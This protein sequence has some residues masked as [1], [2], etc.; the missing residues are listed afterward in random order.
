[1]EDNIICPGLIMYHLRCDNEH[2][3]FK[4]NNFVQKLVQ[5][6]NVKKY[7]L[8]NEIG[9]E[10]KKPH[11]QGA[12]WFSK[13]QLKKDLAK[14]RAFLNSHRIV[15]KNHYAFTEAKNP[16]SLSKYAKKEGDYIHNLSDQEF[17]RIGD[18]KVKEKDEKYNNLKKQL[19]QIIVKYHVN[20]MP[21]FLYHFKEIYMKIYGKMCTN[22][23]TYI[24]LAHE[25]GVISDYNLYQAIGLINNF[26]GTCCGMFISSGV[27]EKYAQ[28]HEPALAAAAAAAAA[29]VPPPIPIL[30]KNKI[31]KKVP[32]KNHYIECD[33]PC[34]FFGQNT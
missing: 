22:K 21:E 14:I 3:Y 8:G 28:S 13:I 10:T 15:G 23:N 18:W 1:M 5:L 30:P 7:L 9:K 19:K 11:I 34:G 20:G 33:K 2:A 24:S 31:L 26:D 17:D 25:C 12:V 4:Q 29:A 16:R 6:Y 27:Y 32:G